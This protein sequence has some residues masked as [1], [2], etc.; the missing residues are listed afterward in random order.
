[1]MNRFRFRFFA[2]TTLLLMAC[3]SGVDQS[4]IAGNWKLTQFSKDGN[5][6]ELKDCDKK[7]TWNFTTEAA[8]PLGDGTKTKKLKAEAPED[9]KYFGFDSKWTITDEKLFISSTR[10]GGMGGSSLAGSMEIVELKDQKMVLKLNK[11]K[12]TLEK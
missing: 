8:K 4:K 7:T 9:C 12:L 10:I 2:I 11:F 3:G 1:M 6:V 5:K